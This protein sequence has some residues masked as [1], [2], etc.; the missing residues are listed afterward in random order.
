MSE[1]LLPPGHA[2]SFARPH[3]Q[4]PGVTDAVRR[5]DRFDAERHAKLDRGDYEGAWRAMLA[6]KETEM[7]LRRTCGAHGPQP[8]ERG[9]N[10]SKDIGT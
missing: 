2:C 10:M 5:Y 4:R 6:M 8:G 7:E 9:V 3:L 1:S